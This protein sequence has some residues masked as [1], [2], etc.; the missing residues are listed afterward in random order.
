MLTRESSE[1]T[2]Q[3]RIGV[4]GMTCASCVAR[5]ERAIEALP[6]VIKAT[7]DLSTESAR[8][9]YL[10]D[11]LSRERIAQAIGEAGYEAEVGEEAPDAGKERQERALALLKRDLML[12]A[13][14][15]APLVLISMTPMFLPLFLPGAET[16]MNSLLPMPVWHWL[17][18]CSLPRCCCGLG[19]VSWFKVGRSF[20]ISRPE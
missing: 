8:V 14:L 12:A 7:V 13:V 15:T 5:V 19:G 20:A 16:L 11:T 6:G 1:M 4:G 9:E 10:P 2:R 17:E 3:L 18:P